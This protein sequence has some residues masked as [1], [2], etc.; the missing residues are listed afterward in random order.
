MIT[1]LI[2]LTIWAICDDMEQAEKKRTK[3]HKELMK[4]NERLLQSKQKKRKI[5]RNI[6]RDE[7]GRTIAQE[8]IEEYV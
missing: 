4:Q 8:I 7:Q 1:L 3:Q 6:I 5:V 2:F